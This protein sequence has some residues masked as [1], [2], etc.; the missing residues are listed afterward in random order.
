LIVGISEFAT[1]DSGAMTESP[2]SL[3]G[4]RLYERGFN[5]IPIMP[6]DKKP[7]MMVDDRWV[8][9]KGWN[10][11]CIE[12]PTQFQIDL[13]SRW[14]MAGLGVACGRGLICI[15]IDIEEAVAPLRAILPV[16]PVEKRGRKGVSLFFSGNTELIR[17]KNFRTP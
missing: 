1:V 3:L 10:E 4:P 15:D 5:P 17:S 13:W 14:P 2:F 12:R 11:F 9:F 7:G 16:T 6:G 8:L